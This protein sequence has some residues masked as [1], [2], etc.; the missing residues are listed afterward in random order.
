[1]QQGDFAW[2]EWNRWHAD[3]RLPLCT[4][5]SCPMVG[6]VLMESQGEHPCVPW[7]VW[8]GLHRDQADSQWQFS[9]P[10]DDSK[11]EKERVLEV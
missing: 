7:T 11:S 8:R 4:R 6:D 2:R 9:R 1:M 3:G 10:A 5:P